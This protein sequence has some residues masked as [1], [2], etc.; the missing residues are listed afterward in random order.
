V[1]SSGY[2]SNV[3]NVKQRIHDNVMR[4]NAFRDDL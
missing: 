4:D 1:R 3:K 2:P